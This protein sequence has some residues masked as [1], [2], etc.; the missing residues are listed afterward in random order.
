MKGP[1]PIEGSEPKQLMAGAALFAA[2][3]LFVDRCLGDPL[4]LLGRLPAMFV[5]FLDVLRL[6]LLLIGVFRLVAARHG[7][8]PV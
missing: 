7:R 5:A 2:V 8:S 1:H 4:R 6:S 3:V